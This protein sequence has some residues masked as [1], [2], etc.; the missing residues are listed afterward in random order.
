MVD[1]TL[2]RVRTTLADRPGALAAI[3]RR[4]GEAGVNI[5]ALQIFP[6]IDEVTD[7]LVLRTP[8]GWDSAL[9]AALLENS[10][11]TRIVVLPSTE[12][13]IVDQ[14]TRYVRAVQAIL[15][16]PM[17]F[18]EVVGQ[19]FDTGAEPQA[20]GH[21]GSRGDGHG[22]G[23]DDVMQMLVGDVEMQI[24]R[25]TPFTVTEHAR[26]TALAELVSDVLQR[27]RRSAGM[28]AAA[29]E[30]TGD[31]APEYVV[32][33]GTVTAV[34][35]GVVVGR[36]TVHDPEE[37]SADLGEEQTRRVTVS[38]EAAWRRRGI[39]TRLLMQAARLARARGADALLLAT[40]ADN[41]AVLPL[42]L[43]AGMRGLIRMGGDRLTVRIPLH[44]LK[45]LVV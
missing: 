41:Q 2:W 44:R 23:P 9:V 40:T 32:D 14:P 11:G 18:P 39:G 10:G 28:S 25:R 15:D 20:E 1:Q 26:G 30:P 45:P 38:V 36:A 31:A 5:L 17:S 7:E 34:L 27:M 24:R 29:S 35:D 21:G 19:L 13:A 16:R 12:A 8:P 4:C 42:V 37:D 33:G 43:A 22:E 6:G 3:A